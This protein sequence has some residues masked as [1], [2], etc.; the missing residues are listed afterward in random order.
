MRSGAWV[1]LRSMSANTLKRAE[2]RFR[3]QGRYI[4]GHPG[5]A[6]CAP[7]AS[8]RTDDSDSDSGDGFHWRDEPPGEPPGDTYSFVGQYVWRAVVGDVLRAHVRASFR[9]P[10]VDCA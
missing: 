3:L 5:A 10:L 1:C 7:L 4:S 6:A 8:T 9:V 2:L